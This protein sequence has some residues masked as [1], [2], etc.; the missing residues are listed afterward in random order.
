MPRRKVVWASSHSE[1]TPKLSMQDS[2]KNDPPRNVVVRNLANIASILGVLP[3]C[4]LFGEHGYQYLLPLI[5]YNNVMDDLDG[6]LA[7]KLNIRSDLGALL[8]NICDAIVHAV[9]VMVVGMHYLQEMGAQEAGYPYLGS[10][11]LAS[12]LV[13]TVAMIVRVATRINPTSATGTGSPTNELIR[14]L[15]FVLLVTQIAGYNPTP[16]LIA[17]FLLHSVSMLAPFKMPYMIRSLTKSATLIGIVNVVLLVAWLLP[18][19]APFIAAAFVVTYLASLATGGFLWLREN[20]SGQAGGLDR[21][22]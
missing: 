12:S 14:H 7:A 13:A 20:C 22:P 8:D 2:P 15:F 17:V 10:I 6:V 21:S 18:S 3:L 1:G 16:Y 9:F 5:L 19:T 4:L 11:C